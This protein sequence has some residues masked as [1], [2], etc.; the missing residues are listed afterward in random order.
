MTETI[1]HPVT[2][3]DETSDA[4]LAETPS[5][6]FFNS[7]VGINKA[8][9][10]TGRNKG[11]ISRD[12]NGKKL[13]HTL[14]DKGQKQYKV[15]DLFQLY[16]FQQPS[17]TK[18]QEHPEP[19]KQPPDLT[20]VT[21][22]DM[23]RLEERLAAKDDALRKAE[24]QIQE[25]RIREQWLKEKYDQLSLQLTGPAVTP[26]AAAPTIEPPTPRTFWQRFFSV[27]DKSSH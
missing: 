25:M 24:E 13:A 26:E 22:A 9:S 7:Y 11:Q 21:T 12:T 18:L 5:S 10:I 4:T 1:Q 14:N 6:H 16:G 27:G 8:A 15:A 2:K 17:E 23:V 3:A 20:T 19:Q